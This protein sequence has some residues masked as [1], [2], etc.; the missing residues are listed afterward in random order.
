MILSLQALTGGCFLLASVELGSV[1]MAPDYESRFFTFF[2]LRSGLLPPSPPPHTQFVTRTT[3][4]S[5][6]NL[7]MRHID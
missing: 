7:S 4:P 5:A 2:A 3:N 1:H 6:N